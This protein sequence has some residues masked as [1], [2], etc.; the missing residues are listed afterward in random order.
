MS[1]VRLKSFDLKDRQ[2]DAIAPEF[3]GKPCLLLEM[4]HELV[5]FRQLLPDLRQKGGAPSAAFENDAVDAR[6]K[7]AQGIGFAVEPERLRFRQHGNL[8]S[9][10]GQFAGRQGRETRVVKGGGAGVASHVV[11][12]GAMRFDRADAASQLAVKRK[13][14]EGSRRLVEPGGTW[15]GGPWRAEFG[16]D[17]GVRQRGEEPPSDL[18]FSGQDEFLP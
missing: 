1:N 5:R 13:G 10:V 11:V 6:T 4:R 17:G 15:Q 16:G 3:R 18:T 8:E 9:H 7:A 2:S 14:D 12:K